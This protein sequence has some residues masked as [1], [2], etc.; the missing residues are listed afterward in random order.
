MATRA[1]TRKTTRDRDQRLAALSRQ[2]ADTRALWAEGDYDFYEERNFYQRVID[3]EE[4]IQLDDNFKEYGQGIQS[5]AGMA[6]DDLTIHVQILNLD[7]PRL[8]CVPQELTIEGKKD[9]EE[10]R[11]WL[12]RSMAIQ[13]PSMTIGR[14]INFSQMVRGVA[15][16]EK[17]WHDP[18][19]PDE[20]HY[21]SEMGEDYSDD[22]TVP[23]VADKRLKVRDKYFESY[24]SHCFSL[25][26]VHMNEMS[27]WPL[28]KPRLFIR[29]FQI[30]YTEA[31]NIARDKKLGG[32]TFGLQNAEGKL[33][34][35]FGES[36]SEENDDSAELPG[37]KFD[38]VI[39][40]ELVDDEWICTEWIKAAD[41]DWDD[42]EQ[43]D[44]YP[45]PFGRAMYF[46]VPSGDMD[47]NATT[48]HRMYKSPMATE[49]RLVYERNFINTLKLVLAR[50]QVTDNFFY[51]DGSTIKPE[52]LQAM[53]ASGF[54]FEGTGQNKRMMF[55]REFANSDQIQVMPSKILAWPFPETPNLDTRLAQ[56]EYELERVR[57]NRLQ[58]G[59]AM[60]ANQ[61]AEA[62]ATSLL[63]QKQA[64]ALPYESHIKFEQD[65]WVE[66]AMA[67]CA[68]IL[69][70][71]KGKEVGHGYSM[72]MTG[73]EPVMRGNKPA[74]TLVKIDADM[75]KRDFTVKVKKSNET[76]AELMQ[77]KLD[78]YQDYAQGTIT[79][80]QLLERV[81]FEDPVRQGEELL[82]AKYDAMIEAELAAAEA[83]M[84][85]VY[86]S[87]LTGTNLAELPLPANAT[88]AGGNAPVGPQANEPAGNALPLAG[89][90][91]PAVTPAP[92]N[93]PGTMG[94]MNPGTG[95]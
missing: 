32:G 28:K 69:H 31:M 67:E 34:I 16:V 57:P 25:N 90:V 47:P 43:Y 18:D 60:T 22:T 73:E 12:A 14:G 70:F 2:I 86:A 51:A 1:K 48:P 38:V 17:R 10:V 24:R 44:E 63:D 6:S 75:L 78:A 30:S 21:R 71:Q 58:I 77:K 37:S 19:E 53:E 68:A 15:C 11:S 23:D 7:E 46:I 82:T 74:G 94:G 50:M 13:N 65:F 9:V 93:S 61:A 76:Q 64:S 4:K 88:P 56:I 85:K 66:N 40:N 36:G 62:P 79:K 54:V 35:V 81:G 84:I 87:A 20:D 41:A 33:K 29:E 80:D 89:S 5:L 8:D 45:I 49:C 72:K 91:G 26:V 3:H 42:G 55:Q 92:V 52:L 95:M 27:W 83:M 39:R 59:Q